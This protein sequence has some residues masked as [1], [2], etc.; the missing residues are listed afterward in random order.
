MLF[1]YKGTA[2]EGEISI[3]ED[4]INISSYAFKGSLQNNTIT[5]PSTIKYIGKEAFSE[6][7]GTLNINSNITFKFAFSRILQNKD[8]GTLSSL[9]EANMELIDDEKAL[10]V[11]REN[12]K[13]N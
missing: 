10:E 12:A 8:V 4:I 2:P 7:K 3:K 13:I 6:C 5:I 11:I 1:K 9:W